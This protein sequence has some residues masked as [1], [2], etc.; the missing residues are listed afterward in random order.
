MGCLK[1]DNYIEE[2][3]G[4]IINM[5]RNKNN[6]NANNQSK[7]TQIQSKP[8][9]V[10]E[11]P[12]T[13]VVTIVLAIITGIVYIVSSITTLNNKYDTYDK[14]FSEF[15]E[16]TNTKLSELSTDIDEI[17]KYIFYD[18]GVKTQLND[19]NEKLNIPTV[20]SQSDILSY[21]PKTSKEPN[22][23]NLVNSPLTDN[24]CIGT[25]TEGNQ[26]I[27][28]DCINKTILLTYTENGNEVYFLGQFNENYNWNG[29]CVINE[30]SS[31]SKLIGI[32]ES[33]F[34]NGNRI[35]Y[36][37]FYYDGNNEWIYTN[38]V[39]NEDGND[40]ISVFYNLTYDKIKN[41][42][43]TNVRITDILYADKFVENFNPTITAYYKGRT[44]ELKFND[45]SGDAYLVK[46]QDD[47][48]VQA[49]YVGKFEDGELNDDKKDSSWEILFEDSI[50]GYK[51]F[52]WTGIF[53]HGRRDNDNNICYISQDEINDI[54]KKY[55][56][57]CELK[58][59]D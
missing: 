45:D 27:A 51:Y 31:D 28:K 54:V 52:Y 15:S 12:I 47:G 38:R 34:D 14:K 58:W 3:E 18:G 37:S 53:N 21:V 2:Y 32:S 46:Y 17:N 6:K 4:D 33:N 48:I 49:L 40:G 59:A 16:N 24:T 42:T 20:E 44:S 22:D 10:I 36:K 39:C 9:K 19:I 5:S 55:N 13:A 8:T 25:D 11:F 43:N 30:Y 23:E 29:Y 7:N 35:D 50:E 26:Y 57:E 1:L 56:F 41:F